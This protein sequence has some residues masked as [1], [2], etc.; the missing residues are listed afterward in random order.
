MSCI[1]SLKN[2]Y[3]RVIVLLIVIVANIITA[4]RI[5]ADEWVYRSTDITNKIWGK[6]HSIKN[7]EPSQKFFEFI[8][9]LL[10]IKV[11]IKIIGGIN[12]PKFISKLKNNPPK[13]KLEA[14]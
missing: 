14:I 1:A 2:D 6:R 8:R 11:V 3:L 10:A 5:L 7:K 4:N 13:R 9:D 12:T